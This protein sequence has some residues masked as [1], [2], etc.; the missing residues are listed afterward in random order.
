M[1]A[2]YSLNKRSQ[3]FLRVL[4]E[5]YIEQGTP[6][7]SRALAQSP[8]INV[9][10]ATIRNVMADLEDLGLI[11]APHTSA[12]RIPTIEGYRLF[13][14]TMLK[15]EKPTSKDIQKLTNKIAQNVDKTQ[16]ID[17]ASQ[18]LS[19]LTHMAGV[20]TLP[21]REKSVFKQ[22]EFLPLSD[23]RVLVILINQNGE[24]HNRV[25]SPLRHYSSNELIE[26]ANCINQN[27]TGM[28]FFKMRD[29]LVK[30]MS[31]VQKDMDK[32]MSRAVQMAAKALEN[33]HPEEDDFVLAGRTNLMDF[34]DFSALDNLRVLFETFKQKSELLHLLE[35]CSD[36]QSIQIFIG[37]ESGYE[38]L[39]RCSVVS[40]PYSVNGELA[41][42]LGVIG[43]TRMAYNRVI[44]IV[45]ITAQILSKALKIG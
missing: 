45:D 33:T 1:S 6:I 16:V 7:G 10:P 17:T 37:A 26:A 42:V 43:P 14:D 21:K 32:G 23:N 9:S 12:G 15:L 4:I 18:F 20:V 29:I 13:V 31:I 22:I 30:E 40:A 3:Q 34:G 24:V 5:R 39:E 41:G 19:H 35:R 36:A 38:P 44:P 11:T 8:E 27:Y 25:I 2:E 28:D